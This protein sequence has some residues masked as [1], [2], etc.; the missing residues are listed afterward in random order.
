MAQQRHRDRHQPALPLHHLDEPP[1]QI[2][3]VARAR[4][5]LGMVLHGKRRPIG[6]G[7]PLVRAVEQRHMRHL[8]SRR[9]R[10]RID[11]KAVVLAGDLHL[12]GRQI[13][14]RLVG[15]AMAAL[16][17]VGLRPQRQ[18]QQLV[19]EADAEHRHAG[20]QHAADRRHRVF[21]GCRRIAWARWTGTRRPACGAGCRSAV[22]VAG[23]TVTRQPAEARQRRMLRFAP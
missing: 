22:A 20:I 1:E 14:H 19:A 12:A 3:A 5:R 7:Q 23:T 16:H 2:V 6:A 8:R 10:L 4:A 13:L 17:L 15:A 11:G 18:R 21:A 9:Q